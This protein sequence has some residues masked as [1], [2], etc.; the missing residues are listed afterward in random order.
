MPQYGDWTLERDA[1]RSQ[2]SSLL[3]FELKPGPDERVDFGVSIKRTSDCDQQVPKAMPR[4]AP[5]YSGA[6][7]RTRSCAALTYRKEDC[8]RRARVSIVHATAAFG[9]T[10]TKPPLWPPTSCEMGEGLTSI[11]ERLC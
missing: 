4:G 11:S 1:V 7:L 8:G 3:K 6:S 10:L 5:A 9:V 2:T